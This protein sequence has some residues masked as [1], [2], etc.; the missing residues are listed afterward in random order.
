MKTLVSVVVPC[1]NEEATIGQLLQALYAQTYAR[2][3]L[4]VL[5]SDGLST[6]RTREIVSG[7]RAEHPD[8]AI[9][10]VDN[11][12]RRIPSAVNEAI[13][14]AQGEIII[15]LDAHSVPYPDYVHRAVATLETG[16]GENVGGVWEIRAGR[17]TWVA[18]SIAAA[19]AHPLGAGDALYRLRPHAGA[20]DTIPFGCFRRDLVDRIGLFDE[21]LL[22]N[23][24]YEFNARIRLAG[25]TV[26]LDPAIRSIYFARS[27]LWQLARQYWRY[28]FWKWRMLRRYPRTLRI[29]QA[30]PPLFLL[31]LTSLSVLSLWVNAARIPLAAA[32]SVYL[33]ALALAGLRLAIEKKKAYLIVGLPLSVLIM[34]FAWGAGFLW[35]IIAGPHARFQHG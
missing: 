24:D 28:G 26:W 33:L 5:V 35:S 14:A 3:S 11:P 23:E 18:E 22:A 30:L 13:K 16:K 29:R 6:D 27:S 4:E 21:N 20:V 17:Q 15:R 8:L 12:R 32:L 2:E 7:F 10:I 25:G 1:L 19:A 31:S 9:R 34:H